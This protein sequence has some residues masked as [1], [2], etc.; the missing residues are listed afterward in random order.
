MHGAFAE[1]FPN[2]I[3]ALVSKR[4][5]VPPDLDV[6]LTS[7]G[8]WL[9]IKTEGSVGARRGLGSLGP[10]R[11][12]TSSYLSTS[13]I[14]WWNGDLRRSHQLS[15]SLSLSSDSPMTTCDLSLIGSLCCVSVVTPA[16][17]PKH[18]SALHLAVHEIT[19]TLLRC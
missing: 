17:R 9:R 8:E 7:R 3:I 11:T 1:P 6:K 2:V 10:R 18:Q 14:R 19:F 4:P 15:L 5:E 16:H 13:W 12:Q